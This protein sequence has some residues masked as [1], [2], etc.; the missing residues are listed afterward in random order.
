VNDSYK[1]NMFASA[2]RLSWLIYNVRSQVIIVD[3]AGKKAVFSD[4]KTANVFLLLV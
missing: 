4:D 2:T 3:V 1:V